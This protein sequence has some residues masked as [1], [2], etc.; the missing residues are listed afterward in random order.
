MSTSTLQSPINIE[1]TTK[2]C[3]N[4]CS[5]KFDYG[6]SDCLVSNENTYLKLSY[7][8]P[9]STITFNDSNYSVQD[10]RLYKPSLNEYYNS[11]VDA[12]LIINHVGN[13]VNNLLVCIPLTT[14]NAKS[15]S[16]TMFSPLI[17]NAPLQGEPRA[18]INVTN[19][20]LNNVV[21]SGPFYSYQGTLPYDDLNGTYNVVVFDSNSPQVNINMSSTS[22]ETLG[23]IIETTSES[24][25]SSY[26][27]NNLF[28]N[29]DGTS[30][31]PSSD[32]IYIDCQPVSS[33]GTPID[34]TTD[35]S[36]QVSD[37]SSNFGKDFLNILENPWFDT[38]VGVI[39]GLG[40]VYLI[41]K[42]V[43]GD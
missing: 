13:G 8:A 26:D 1:S 40:L 12:E 32:D 23:T 25:N 4:T 38:I 19:Y 6:N 37:G 42:K 14:S 24:V 30:E 33:D 7:N 18:S 16:L 28:Y 31:P 17:Q 2:T 20:N 10:I 3:T 36:Q 43:L 9:S 11:H 27:S 35:S 5:Y 22:M 15:N 29:K 41:K 39:G 21:P 34:E